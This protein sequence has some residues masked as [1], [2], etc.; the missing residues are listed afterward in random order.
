[1]MFENEIAIL[2]FQLKHFEK[3]LADLPAEKLYE[4]APGHGHSIGWLLGHLALSSEYGIAMLGGKVEHPQWA[5]IFGAGSDGVASSTTGPDRETLVAAFRKNHA[6]L[7][8]RASNATAEHVHQPHS[9]KM[10][11]GSSIKTIGNVVGML[12]TNHF[13]FHLS[14]LSSCRRSCGHEKLF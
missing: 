2:T 1:M 8:E 10:F 5:P 6:E 4:P 3:V 13:G 7:L 14:Q 9:V 11:E 12:M